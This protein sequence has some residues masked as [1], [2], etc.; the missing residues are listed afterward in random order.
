MWTLWHRMLLLAL[1]G[2]HSVAWDASTSFNRCELCRMAQDIRKFVTGIIL[3]TFY[4]LLQY[5]LFNAC[6]YYLLVVKGILIMTLLNIF[7]VL[8]F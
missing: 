1:T 2:V 6:G 7:D 5:G 4:L 8:S 3:F